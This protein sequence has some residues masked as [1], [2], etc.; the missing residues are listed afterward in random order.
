[1]RDLSAGVGAGLQRDGR[2]KERER[3][4]RMNRESRR[5][6]NKERKRRC[7]EEIEREGEGMENVREEVRKRE[8]PSSAVLRSESVDFFLSSDLLLLCRLGKHW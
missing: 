3:E 5:S 2:E 8:V 6:V 1:M 4:R 7:E